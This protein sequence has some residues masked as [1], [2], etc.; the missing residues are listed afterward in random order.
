MHLCLCEKELFLIKEFLDAL[1]LDQKFLAVSRYLAALLRGSP[2]P[3]QP[4]QD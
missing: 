1:R 2:F 3:L 4:F